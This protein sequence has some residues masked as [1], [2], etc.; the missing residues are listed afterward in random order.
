MRGLTYP[1]SHESL[2]K[3]HLLLVLKDAEQYLRGLLLR[4][5]E[6]VETD[7]LRENLHQSETRQVEN[8][9]IQCRQPTSD[10]V[11]KFLN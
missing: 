9:S 1:F 11:R 4:P 3:N 7:R 8:R 10:K 2:S 6:A 5:N